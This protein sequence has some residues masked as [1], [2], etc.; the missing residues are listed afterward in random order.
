MSQYIRYYHPG[1]YY[2]FTLVT[3]KRRPLFSDDENVEKL[4]VAIRKVKINHPFSLTAF[5]IL[6]DHMHCIWKLPSN[7][8]N[9]ST[10][11]R[12]IKNYF[13]REMQSPINLRKE[14]EIWQHRFWEHCIRDEN[15]WRQHMDYIHYNPVKHNLVASP[16][17]WKH[18]S[19][20]YWVE[21]G[22]YEENWALGEIDDFSKIEVGG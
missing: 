21:R 14:K 6:P 17:N 18:S 8:K 13:S 11:W 20:Y 22:W 9:F 1:G 7:D 4:R 3:H 19:F 2:F 12:L 16:K 10:R 15:D 5:V